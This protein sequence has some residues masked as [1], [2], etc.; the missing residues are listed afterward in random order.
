M[1]GSRNRN[2]YSIPTNLA[3][4]EKKVQITMDADSLLPGVDREV[5]KR[6]RAI[7]WILHGA[8]WFAFVWYCWIAWVVSGDFK[9]NSRGRGQEPDWY[10]ALMRGWELFALVVTVLILWFF[11]FRP[12]IRTGRMSFD[13]LF[14]LGCALMFFQEPWINWTNYQ[15]LY[16]TTSINFGSWLNH[17]PGWSYPNAEV[18]PV[19]AWAG[20]AYLWLVAIPAMAG[21]KF[22]GWLTRRQP[23]MSKIKLITLTYGAFCVFDL[24]LESFITRTQL[25]SYGSVIP[26]LALFA[27]TDHQFPIYETISWAGTYTVLSSL[28][29]FRDDRGRS[30]PERGIDGFKFGG[31]RMKTFARFL[32]I[33][34]ACQLAILVPY[35]IPYQLYG[36]H[37]EMPAVFDER[38]WRTGG[39]CGPQTNFECPGP[40]V[41][42][43][44]HDSVTNRIVPEH[45]R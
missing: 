22:M 45:S 4:G 15:F 5:E 7:L 11:V 38:P 42:I 33:A 14:V 39:V 40:G 2:W 12:K 25:F 3:R 8:L 9:T 13:G 43:P 1:R 26:E 27:G 29:F 18:M 34:G 36:L 23:G 20:T 44:R 17:I 19:S 16:S 28:H 10:V 41:P 35:N 6:N 31:A 32:A 30:L 24:V 37:A 21:S